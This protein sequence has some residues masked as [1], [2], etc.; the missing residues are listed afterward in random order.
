MS[1]RLPTQALE[2]LG[3][4]CEEL[5]PAVHGTVVVDV[6]LLGHGGASPGQGSGARVAL[7][8]EGPWAH[9]RSTPHSQLGQQV[10]GG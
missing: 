9:S 2:S 5:V 4:A 7:L 6:A 3:L 1:T 10:T 8:L